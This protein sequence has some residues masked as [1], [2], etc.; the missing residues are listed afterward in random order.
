MKSD[1][2]VLRFL[3]RRT[4]AERK[5]LVGQA[6]HSHRKP[7]GKRKD[8]RQYPVPTCN[9]CSLKRKSAAHARCPNS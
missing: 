6:R 2:F 4:I 1:C 7:F 3:G 8:P 5:P 9:I